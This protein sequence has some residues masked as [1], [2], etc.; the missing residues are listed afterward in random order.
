VVAT[1]VV[2]SGAASKAG[3]GRLLA[4]AGVPTSAEEA[5]IAA[6]KV[7]APKPPEPPATVAPSPPE[8]K[9][10]KLFPNLIPEDVP[11]KVGSFRLE[12]RD[13][14][15]VTVS[16]SGDVFTARGRY[17]FVTQGGKITVG[18]APRTMGFRQEVKHIDLSKGVP[19]EYAGE[20]EF[21][22]KGQVRTWSND[23]GHHLPDPKFAPQAGLPMDR[24][25]P[26]IP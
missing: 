10:P 8:Q 6:K 19:V 9:A 16:S 2:A 22:Q 14:K 17:V 26:V 24:F 23:S 4:S 18:R 25:R 3:K 13:G 15:W 7:V 11:K 1:E 12:M 20:V 5:A 21:T